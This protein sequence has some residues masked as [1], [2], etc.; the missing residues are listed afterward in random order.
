MQRYCG[1]QSHI[2]GYESQNCVFCTNFSGS[3]EL[4]VND[5]KDHENLG[6]ED[7]EDQEAHAY[8]HP[9][10]PYPYPLSLIQGHRG[11]LEHIP[12]LFGPKAGVDP[13]Q[14]SSP[15]QGHM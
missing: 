3:V 12:V 7:Q 11:L 4:L 10:I 5:C 14:V 6:E 1:K 2:S 9:S 8:E 13:G 15:L